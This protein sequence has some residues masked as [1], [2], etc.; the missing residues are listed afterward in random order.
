[1]KIGALL[2]IAGVAFVIYFFIRTGKR[3]S[4][5]VK[6]IFKRGGGGGGP[7]EH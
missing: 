1:M 2:A 6:S 5:V 7:S 3:P 4:D